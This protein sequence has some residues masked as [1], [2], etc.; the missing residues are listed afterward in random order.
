[1]PAAAVKLERAGEQL[2]GVALLVDFNA[3]RRGLPAALLQFRLGVEEVHLARAA[4]LHEMDHRPGA[5]GEVAAARPEV[6]RGD[7]RGRQ[8]VLGEE[9]GQGQPADART[10]GPPA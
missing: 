7:L 8:A 3:L 2:V 9:A 5:G 10:G 4:V 1:A 6:L